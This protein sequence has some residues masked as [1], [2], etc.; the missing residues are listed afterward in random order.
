MSS[1]GTENA[2]VFRPGLN[3][4]RR[5]SGT[6]LETYGDIVELLR[7]PVDSVVIRALAECW[8]PAYRC[9][10]FGKVYM[11]PTLEEYTT[12]LNISNVRRH[13][14]YTKVIRPKGFITKMITL[15]GKTKEWVEEY[16]CDEGISWAQ[17]KSLIYEQTPSKRR[18][19]HFALAI[20]GMVIFPKNEDHFDIALID[21]VEAIA[22]KNPAPSIFAE[23][24]LSLNQCRRLGGGQFTGCTS[25]LLVWWW[26]HSWIVEKGWAR[27]HQSNFSPMVDF[28]DKCQIPEHSKRKDWV[29]ALRNV[30]DTEIVWKAYWLP[31]EDILFRCGNDNFVMLHGLWGAI[32]YTPLIVLRQFST[33]QFVPATHG[34]K[35]TEFSFSTPGYRERISKIYTA[36]QKPH[37]MNFKMI[38]PGFTPAYEVWRSHKINNNTPKLNLEDELTMEERLRRLPTE[39]ELLKEDMRLMNLER[40]KVQ[41]N[42]SD[43]KTMQENKALKVKITE[44]EAAVQRGHQRI[45]QLEESR[46]LTNPELRTTLR[47][48]QDTIQRQLE[49][50]ER[51]VNQAHDVARQVYEISE[52][53]IALRV[54]VIPNSEEERRILGLMIELER[55]GDRA[56]FYV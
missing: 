11:T 22:R 49:V 51:A 41:R 25:L 32:E 42:F 13:S 18:R 19:D 55:L 31:K 33:R 28:L 47:Q 34:L 53:A 12:L 40:E 54:F 30:K 1:D 7:V 23:T 15:T 46:S 45:Q 35:E 8:N 2:S 17:L 37:C 3:M 24:F 39:A 21:F 50:M 48:A 44:L 9:F 16:I 56:R 26:S 38:E 20:Y 52:E 5:G 29:E 14:I 36:W 6:A 27:R 4:G 10:T 43:E